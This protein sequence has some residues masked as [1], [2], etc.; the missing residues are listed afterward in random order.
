MGQQVEKLKQ[1]LPLLAIHRCT[2]QFRLAGWI[3]Q[4]KP[5]YRCLFNKGY[6]PDHRVEFQSNTGPCLMSARNSDNH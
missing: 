4:R 2:R 5:T 1:R 6:V 3:A